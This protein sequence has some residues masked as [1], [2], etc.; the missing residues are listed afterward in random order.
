MP[1]GFKLATQ[2]YHRDAS[3]LSDYAEMPLAPHSTAGSCV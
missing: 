2:Q 1:S 3:V